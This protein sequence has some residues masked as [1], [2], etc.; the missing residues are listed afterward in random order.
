MGECIY[1]KKDAGLFRRHHKECAN[2]HNEGVQQVISACINTMSAGVDFEPLEINALNTKLDQIVT[3]FHLSDVSEHRGILIDAWVQFMKSHTVHDCLAPSDAMRLLFFKAAFDLHANELD[4]KCNAYH[5]FVKSSILSGILNGGEPSTLKE[6]L[7]EYLTEGYL[8][9]K[10]L[11]RILVDAWIEALHRFSDDNIISVQH[12][13][14]LRAYQMF[15]ELSEDELDSNGGAYQQFAQ[16][17]IFRDISEGR[18]P[19]KF[20][21]PTEFMLQKDERLLWLFDSAS[22]YETQKQIKKEYVS[23]F[24]GI[25]F[26]VA[27]GIWIRTGGSRGHINQYERTVRVPIATGKLGFTN[28]HIYFSGDG[29]SFRIRYDKIVAIP[30][31]DRGIEIQQEGRAKPFDIET[32]N[33]A[34]LYNLIISARLAA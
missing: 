29:K 25:S 1:C 5:D 30:V 13:K 14:H 9:N 27:K 7:D 23:G 22:L 32:G 28:K 2:K 3:E 31:Y 4:A 15:F 24:S 17:C 34:F 12:A 8:T 18:V 26:R 33:G 19:V 11:H 21:L 16:S 10:D 6:I 20:N